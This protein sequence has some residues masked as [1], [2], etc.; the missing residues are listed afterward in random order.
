[1]KRKGR[2]NGSQGGGQAR[3]RR[4]SARRSPTHPDGTAAEW[5]PL[6]AYAE[7]FEHP[8]WRQWGEVARRCGHG[9]GDFF[10]LK[11]FIE[12]I[13]TGKRP[14]VDVYDAVT[15]SSIVPLSGESS[16][17]GGA[18]VEVPDFGPVR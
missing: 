15:W 7:E 10:V 1:M 17:L 9:G 8:D 14:P 16:R 12:A 2:N 6:S 18:P 3:G 5:E 13:L 11:H 4:R